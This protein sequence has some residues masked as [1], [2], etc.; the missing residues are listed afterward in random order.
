MP[1]IICNKTPLKVAVQLLPSFNVSK[2][3]FN[4]FL[5]QWQHLEPVTFRL[6][7]EGR[8]TK[9]ARRITQPSHSNNTRNTHYKLGEHNSL[10]TPSS[11]HLQSENSIA[12][13]TK[14]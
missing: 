8:G 3:Q 5:K 7:V 10:I 13:K 6:G 1:F 14:V 12:P 4:S 9:R 2:A 11:M